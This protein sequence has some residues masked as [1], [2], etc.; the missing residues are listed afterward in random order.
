M[1]TADKA[2]ATAQQWEA[3]KA[4][5]P[6]ALVGRALLAHI[7]S[8]ASPQVTDEQIMEGVKALL[9]ATSSEVES[10][11]PNMLSGCQDEVRRVFMAM[12]ACAISAPL[13]AEIKG[14]CQH[15]NSRYPLHD[16]E[17]PVAVNG[18]RKAEQPING[19]VAAINKLRS[20]LNAMLT[21]FGMDQE[22]WN[23]ATFKQANAAIAET[24]NLP[25]FE[26]MFSHLV[27]EY[28]EIRIALD[29]GPVAHADVL[30]CI[31]MLKA[32]LQE[33]KPV[34]AGEFEHFNNSLSA[35]S[36]FHA[37]KIRELQ[38]QPQQ[39]TK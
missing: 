13:A 38:S 30:D 2:I 28:A 20:A 29:C 36:L 6:S 15:C 9:C 25:D 37:R 19:Y 11:S 39:V 22:E 35:F 3:E 10:Y 32:Q 24:E 31:R 1:I 17:C 7:N 23:S 27:I 21:Q 14:V 18:M 26:A 8:L 5:G 16:L 34:A 4:A 12:S 33:A